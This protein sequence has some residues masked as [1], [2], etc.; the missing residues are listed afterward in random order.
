MLQLNA[1]QR[2]ARTSDRV[3]LFSRLARDGL[4][5]YE[6][7]AEGATQGVSSREA[8]IRGRGRRQPDVGT[9]GGEL[10]G[11]AGLARLRPHF[12]TCFPVGLASIGNHTPNN[13]SLSCALNALHEYV[14]KTVDPLGAASHAAMDRATLVYSSGRII[15]GLPRRSSVLASC[16]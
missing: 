10:R 12:A 15:L 1:T 11:G 9:T 4:M 8:R 6:R 16:A 5:T 13:N 14:V 3:H 2:N 7:Y